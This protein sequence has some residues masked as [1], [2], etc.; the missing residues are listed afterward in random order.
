MSKE[1]YLQNIF[2]VSLS[3]IFVNYLIYKNKE[4]FPGLPDYFEKNN[5]TDFIMKSIGMNISSV[6]IGDY[7]GMNSPSDT[8]QMMGIVGSIWQVFGL[9]D[10]ESSNNLSKTGQMTLI[11]VVTGVMTLF[12]NKLLF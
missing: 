7:I 12:L 11:S 10:K 6:V 1:V 3:T 2:S 5:L 9:S 8:I 4:T